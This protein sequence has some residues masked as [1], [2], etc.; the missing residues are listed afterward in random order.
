E[1]EVK[2]GLF[3]D[4][5]VT[6]GT[7]ILQLLSGKDKTLLIRRDTIYPIQIFRHRS[8]SHKV[9]GNLPFLILDFGL[10][11]VDGV[12]RLDLKGDRLPR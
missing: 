5:V 6:Q 3:L 12:R 7:A 11:I 8:R 9:F 1:N 2:G 10:D 4:V